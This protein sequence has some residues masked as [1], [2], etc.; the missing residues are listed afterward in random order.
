MYKAC[1]RRESMRAGDGK[2]LCNSMWPNMYMYGMH[3][4]TSF[5]ILICYVGL[6]ASLIMLL[7]WMLSGANVYKKEFARKARGEI[8]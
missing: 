2:Q 4:A 5:V 1:E 3:V 6:Y 8:Y 7:C